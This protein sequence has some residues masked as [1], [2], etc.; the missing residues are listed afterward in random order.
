MH[1]RHKMLPLHV[2][3]P[4]SAYA[5]LVEEKKKKRRAGARQQKGKGSTPK[6][7]QNVSPELKGS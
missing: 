4:A 6:I 1:N 7:F 5:Y 3:E 2:V